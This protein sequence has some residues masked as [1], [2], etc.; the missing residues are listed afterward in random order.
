MSNL[1]GKKIRGY[2][3]LELLYAGGFATTP[4]ADAQPDV[5]TVFAMPSGRFGALLG[6][7]GNSGVFQIGT[8]GHLLSAQMAICSSPITSTSLMKHS[9]TI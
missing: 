7:I 6:R 5:A 8:G 3:L 9:Q 2:G 1:S 4:I